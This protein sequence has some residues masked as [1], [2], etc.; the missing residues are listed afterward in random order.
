MARPCC[1]NCI[2]SYWSLSM[3]RSSFAPGFPCGPLCANHPN[4]PGQLRCVSSAGICRNYRP[5]PETPTQPDGVVRRIALSTGQ[6]ALVDAANFECL[7]RQRWRLIGAGYV[8]RYEKGKLIYMHREIMQ[9]PKGMLVDHIDRNRQNN[10][11]SNLR[12]CTHSENNY[13]RAKRAGSAS[14]YR[15]VYRRKSDGRLYAMAFFQGEYLWLG[16]FDTEVD[17]ARAYDRKVVE[18][19]LTFAYLNFPEEWPPERRQQVYTE[20][21]PLRDTLEAKRKGKRKK[22]KVQ[23]LAPRHRPAKN[24]VA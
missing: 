19:G 6:Y 16:F 4:A 7:N 15:G 20:A 2:Y 18:L 12:L 21:Q 13:N 24:A 9:A 10:C 3:K 8:V 17:A 22:V 23:R 5:K 14:S 1:A 11:R